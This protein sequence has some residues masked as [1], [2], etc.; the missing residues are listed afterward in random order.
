MGKAFTQIGVYPHVRNPG[1]RTKD[2]SFIVTI[3]FGND[4]ALRHQIFAFMPPLSG[5]VFDIT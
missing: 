3:P 1:M 5:L 2:P 4:P